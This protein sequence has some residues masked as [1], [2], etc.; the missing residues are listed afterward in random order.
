MQQN[1]QIL[2]KIH[3]D[4]KIHVQ[5]LIKQKKEEQESKY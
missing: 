4:L 3:S 2:K 5:S 1:I